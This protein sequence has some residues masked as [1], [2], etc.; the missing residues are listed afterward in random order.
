[1]GVRI[2]TLVSMSDPLFSCLYMCVLN[3]VAAAYT[4]FVLTPPCDVSAVTAVANSTFRVQSCCRRHPTL[5]LFPK[6]TPAHLL[7]I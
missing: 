1:M 2:G 5:D 3:V 7:Y 4:P 6:K